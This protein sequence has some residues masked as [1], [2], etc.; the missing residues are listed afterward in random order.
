MYTG[1][2]IITD[3]LQIHLDAASFRS[4]PRTGTAWTDLVSNTV[5][6]PD[7]GTPTFDSEGLVWDFE[8]GSQNNFKCES[9]LPDTNTQQEY[10]R[11]AWFNPETVAGG[12]PY[13]IFLN[14]VGNNG[15]MMLGIS[16][17]KICYHSYVNAN[18]TGTG[19]QD[20][21][22][23]GQTTLQIG[24]WY[25]GAVTFSRS[26]LV[27]NLYLN[28]VL[29][30]QHTSIRPVGNAGS[31]NLFVGGAESYIQ[32]RTFDGL[33]SV[34]QHYNRVL[35]ATEIAQNYNALKSRFSL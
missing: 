29:D 1:P 22:L 24:N 18:S 4:Y 6:N 13:Y 11:I 14:E 32:S 21:T 35:S 19:N 2:H 23:S 5:F 10:T 31:D 9:N 7:N 33:I 34:V 26:N 3:G 12:N 17:S 27:V 16:N 20:Y 28:G 15:D 30:K 25:M 8:N